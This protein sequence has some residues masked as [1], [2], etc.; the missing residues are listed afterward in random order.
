MTGAEIG[1]MLHLL[2]SYSALGMPCSCPLDQLKRANALWLAWPWWDSPRTIFPHRGYESRGKRSKACL[3]LLLGWAEPSHH[4]ALFTT[5]KFSCNNCVFFT[6]LLCVYLL[7]SLKRESVGGHNSRLWDS[8]SWPNT[9]FSMSSCHIMI[10]GPQKLKRW[11][12]EFGHRAKVPATRKTVEI[13]K[14]YSFSLHHSK[15]VYVSAV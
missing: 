6:V 5:A 8:A 10:Y 11:N 9:I 1:S 3:G 4:P 14:N 7:W 2:D 15:N 13:K 12:K